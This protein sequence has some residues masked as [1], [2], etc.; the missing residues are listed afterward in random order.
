MGVLQEQGFL[1]PSSRQKKAINAMLNESFAPLSSKPGI[2]G[3]RI[4]PSEIGSDDIF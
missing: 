4:Q 3:I 2:L 1:V